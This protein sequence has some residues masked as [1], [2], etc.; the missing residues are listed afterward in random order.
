MYAGNERA[1]VHY[2]ERVRHLNCTRACGGSQR[3]NEI[4]VSCCCDRIRIG[5][6]SY[7]LRLES[8]LVLTHARECTIAHVA[9]ESNI[10][11]HT[12]VWSQQKCDYARVVM[13][14]TNAAC[15]RVCGLCAETNGVPYVRACVR[16]CV[17]AAC[18]CI[19]IMC[20]CVCDVAKP[21]TRGYPPR[22]SL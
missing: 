16:A 6:I 15:T 4:H 22:P 14:F 19:C 9:R 18:I 3:C 17:R 12:R 20:V 13:R 2:S 5:S 10:L 1:S 7:K 11:F 8:R 21:C